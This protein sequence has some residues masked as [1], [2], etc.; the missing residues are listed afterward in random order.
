MGCALREGAVV[1]IALLLAVTVGSKQ[2][3]ESV[4]LGELATQTLAAEG[5]PAGHRRELGGTRLLFEALRS[6]Q[7]DVYPEYTGTLQQELVPGATDLQ[8]ALDKLGIHLGRPLGFDD[9]YALGMQREV[10]ARL[11]ISAISD[12][13]NHPELQFGFS[14]EF[15]QRKDGWP[16]VRE[17]YGA[18]RSGAIAAVDL[19]ST[20]A[21]IRKND[22]VVLRDDRA[23]FPRYEAVLLSRKGLPAEAQKALGLLEGK[24]TQQEMIDLNVRTLIDHVPER[25]AASEFLQRKL[26]LKAA[27]AS[28]GMAARLWKRTR[29]HLFL[30]VVS[31]GAA[32]LF[33]IPLG[34]I[35]F[36]RR[37]LGAFILGATGV[38]QT[39]PSL[40]L[41]VF[42]IPLLGIGAGPA[43]VALFLYSL[44]PIARGTHSGLTGIA[45][46]LIE[47]AHALGLPPAAV[48]RR[49]ELPLASRSILA[50]VKT[51]A[52]I[53]V[54]T[55]TLG[56]LIGAG[57]Y[58]QTILTGIRLA[59]TALILEGAIPAA[60]L[61]L[62][63]E[64]L[65]NLIERFVVPRGL[66]L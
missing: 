13:V 54:G 37:R 46:E 3:T 44:L 2:F 62:V 30:V 43:I 19:Y 36:R 12:L 27:S 61:A 10:A 26:Q 6:G 63:V 48:L 33:A 7:I 5:V 52:V 47:S 42:M 17:V 60:L 4:I 21:E 45:P 11:H 40:A 8:S 29:E 23:A 65:F 14:N 34:V 18:L 9:S 39:I 25:Q 58:G 28:D 32:V 56:A 35:S 41:L 15:M 50:G 57:G 20:D 24:I 64:A 38:V 66:R 31:L 51:A 16:R 22:L 49:V 59:D 55:A 53:C 1:I